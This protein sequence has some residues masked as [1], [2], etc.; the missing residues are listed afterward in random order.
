MEE[1]PK[2]MFCPNCGKKIQSGLKFCPYCGHP[3]N[4]HQAPAMTTSH[5]KSTNHVKKNSLNTFT[6]KL[7]NN[8]H[9][10]LYLEIA[11]AAIIVLLIIGCG[12]SY[13]KN[14]TLLLTNLQTELPSNKWNIKSTSNHKHNQ[15]LESFTNNTMTSTNGKGKPQRTNVKINK[16]TLTLVKNPKY[17]FTTTYKLIHRDGNI[18]D[19]QYVGYTYHH[20]KNNVAMKK[21]GNKYFVNKNGIT[22][23]IKGKN[24]IINKKNA[25]L[26]SPKTVKGIEKTIQQMQSKDEFIEK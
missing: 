21:I 5:H 16:Q 8:K 12:Y 4:H 3:L 18:L 9:N 24:I 26:I 25:H 19:L 17:H 15:N 2:N 11:T 6:Q 13:A 14:H 7:K 1:R 20:G 23:M 22:F 10:K